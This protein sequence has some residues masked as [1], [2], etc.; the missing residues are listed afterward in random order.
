[1]KFGAK[2]KVLF[3]CNANVGRSQAAE[4]LFKRLSSHEAESAGTRADE[5]VARSNPPT[6]TLKDTPSPAVP[7]L[8]ELGV[9]ISQNVRTQLTEDLVRQVDRV[10][11]IADRDTWPDYL[12]NSD[13]VVVWDIQDT[14]GM[15]SDEAQLLLDEI[16][17]RVEELVRETG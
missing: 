10:I 5:I 2:M 17:R 15:G 11:V 14:L 8:K 9:D 6:R 1:M 7:Y 3:V 4:A 13:K 16:K 12:S